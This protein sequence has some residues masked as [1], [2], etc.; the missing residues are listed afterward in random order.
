M[1]ARHGE[2]SRATGQCPTCGQT[3]RLWDKQG[4][5]SP[6]PATCARHTMRLRP[7]GSPVPCK[8]IGQ[9]PVEWQ[10]YITADPAR[11]AAHDARVAEFRDK[12]GHHRHR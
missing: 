1:T 5:T 12:H 9:V 10:T 7:C 4:T 6:Y 11:L 8:G 3:V 2:P